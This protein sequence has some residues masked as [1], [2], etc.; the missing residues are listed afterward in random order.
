MDDVPDT[1]VIL[2][3]TT[4]VIAASNGVTPSQDCFFIYY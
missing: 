2:D 4:P 3:T 1:G